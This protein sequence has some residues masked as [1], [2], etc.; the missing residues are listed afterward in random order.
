MLPVSSVK[1]NSYSWCGKKKNLFPGSAVKD[2]CIKKKT[3]IRPA[4]MGNLWKQKLGIFCKVFN[5]KVR[6]YNI[7]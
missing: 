1:S 6:V 2:L 4:L 7:A 3:F 5:L